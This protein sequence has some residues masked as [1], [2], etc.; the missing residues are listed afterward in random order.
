MDGGV[1]FVYCAARPQETHRVNQRNGS[2]EDIMDED[3]QK[4][5]SQEKEQV[6]E[7]PV[8]DMTVKELRDIAK[9]IP[10]LSGISALKKEELLA[11]IKKERKTE[12]GEEKKDEPEKP[13]D[14]MTATELREI[15]K[16]I[17][18]I[19]GAHAL[20]KEELL[21]AIKK[22]RGI[23]EETPAKKK[24]IKKGGLVLSVKELKVKIVQLRDEKETARKAKDR[25]RV[26]ILRRRIN[27][28]KKQTRRV[29]GA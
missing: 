12:P 13:L 8:E 19:D 26:D 27:R 1:F 6:S 5:E 17:P 2:G 7:K 28:L 9:G 23:E 4:Q 15:A 24:K 14:K 21:A 29:A 11:V 16:E 25:K 10:G 3:I 22:A 20:K 18:G